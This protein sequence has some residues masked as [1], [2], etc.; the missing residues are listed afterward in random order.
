MDWQ[1]D[2]WECVLAEG[3]MPEGVALRNAKGPGGLVGTLGALGAG[4]RH[5]SC[6]AEWAAPLC[7]R[8]RSAKVLVP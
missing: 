5:G 2:Q 4:G 6:V 8:H 1:A 3:R 7:W